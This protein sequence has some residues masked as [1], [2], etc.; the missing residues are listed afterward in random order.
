MC[1]V[2]CSLW[3]E[4]LHT[5]HHAAKTI[6]AV[7]ELHVLSGLALNDSEHRYHARA[8]AQKMR[9]YWAHEGEGRTSAA[10]PPLMALLFLWRTFII[11]TP[12]E[13]RS[14]WLPCLHAATPASLLGYMSGTGF[15]SNTADMPQQ[16]YGSIELAVPKMMGTHSVAKMEH[17]H[18][19]A[20]KKVGCCRRNMQ[21]AHG[22]LDGLQ[23]H[24]VVE[25]A[26]HLCYY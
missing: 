8:V 5:G 25:H 9:K 7:W 10:H 23:D 14:P 18:H 21:G 12:A 17:V 22:G 6:T 20:D 16:L 2:K 15:Q 3:L 13:M 26:L 19:Q 11:P 1:T 24:A 4:L